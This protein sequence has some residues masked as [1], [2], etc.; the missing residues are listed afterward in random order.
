MGACVLKLILISSIWDCTTFYSFFLMLKNDFQKL[1]GLWLVG[2]VVNHVGIYGSKAAEGFSAFQ[3]RSCYN[4]HC[5]PNISLWS[6]LCNSGSLPISTRESKQTAHEL[7]LSPDLRRLWGS[8]LWTIWSSLHDPR[9]IGPNHYKLLGWPLHLAD[10][11]WF[12]WRP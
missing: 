3:L 1:A 10:S 5:V 4:W 2:E 9:V 11:M 7:F 6:K 12:V 8:I